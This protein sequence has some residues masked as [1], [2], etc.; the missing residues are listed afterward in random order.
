MQLEDEQKFVILITGIADYYAKELSVSAINLY[1]EGLRSYDFEAIER[2]LWQHTQNPDSGQFMPKIADVTKVLQGRTEDQAQ[3]AWSKVDRAVRQI[4]IYT[5]VAF[6]DPIIHRV[7]ADMGGWVPMC[8]HDDDGWPFV[9]KEFITRYRGFRISGQIPA[10]PKYLLGSAST[11]NTA[12]G[13]GKPCV[14]LLGSQEA[15]LQVIHGGRALGE[16]L[17]DYAPAPAKQARM[18]E[19]AT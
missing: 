9:A 8:S 2:A 14:R 7:V 10:Y 18:L 4:G 17:I 12:G 15:A 6:D 3:L 16:P 5:D 1:W 13:H 19:S 11:H